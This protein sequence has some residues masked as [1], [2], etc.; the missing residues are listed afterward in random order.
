MCWCY[1]HFCG[2]WCWFLDLQPVF[3]WW[4][5]MAVVYHLLWY[6]CCGKHMAEHAQKEDHHLRTWSNRCDLRE[7]PLAWCWLRKKLCL[8]TDNFIKNIQTL[9]TCLYFQHNFIVHFFTFVIDWHRF[10]E[11]WDIDDIFVHKDDNWSDSSS[12]GSVDG[13]G[14]EEWATYVVNNVQFQWIFTKSR[15]TKCDLTKSELL[16][17]CSA[18]FER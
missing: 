12:E 11:S 4:S 9:S 13:V 14:E 2:T 15:V 3:S 10:C 16:Q 18:E 5:H 8:D 7:T 6:C 17:R 1:F